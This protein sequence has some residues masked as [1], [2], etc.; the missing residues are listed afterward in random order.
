MNKQ[1]IEVPID[2]RYISEWVDFDTNLLRGHSIINK[3]ITGCGFT[4]YSLVNN[5]PTILCSPRK[6]LL[7]NKHQQH[8]DHTFLV[9]NS[10]EKILSVDSPSTNKTGSLLKTDFSEEMLTENL[11]VISNLKSSLITYLFNCKIAQITPKILVTYDS[12]KYVLEV[13][14]KELSNYSIIVDEFQNIFM[15]A[16]FKAETELNFIDVLQICPN[17]TYLSATPYIEEYLDELNEF[18]NLPYYELKWDQSHLRTIDIEFKKTSSISR[19]VDKIIQNYLSGN[20]PVKYD[21]KRNR[22]ESR[23]IVFYVNSVKM[24]KSI[25]SRNNLTQDQVNV[26][27]ANT[28]VNYDTLKK[29]KIS[30]GTAPLKGEPHKMFTF[31]TRTTYVGAD[32]YSTCASTVVVSDCKIDSLTSDIRMDFPQIMGRQ[33][34]KENVFRN[35]CTFIFNLSDNSITMEQFKEI[36]N[37]KLKESEQD[38]RNYQAVLTME[39]SEGVKKILTDFR[40]RITAHKYQNDYT[41]I[42]V[43]EGKPIINKL[44]LLAEKRA[45]ELRSNTYKTVFSV[46]DEF[47]DITEDISLNSSIEMHQ[48]IQKCM[49]DFNAQQIFE[50]KMKILC[51][52]F[53][54]DCVRGRLS[55]SD[56]P[57]IPKDYRNYL[58]YLG[59]E[60]I[61][62][63]GYREIVLKREIANIL[64][65]ESIK[66]ELVNLFEVGKRY[67]L[68]DI[69]ETLRGVYKTLGLTKTPKASDLEDYFEVKEVIF[70]NSETKKRDRGYEIIK[71]IE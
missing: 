19:E 71:L 51:K 42:S 39:G 31:C 41:G 38:L 67:L 53:L 59:P 32:F 54:D 14:D 70:Y 18:K 47:K 61:R 26:I 62:A 46:Y 23:E 21:E 50:N 16:S 8:Q 17:V 40:L 64:G 20:F 1:I 7:E 30:L 29:I 57:G 35:E 36:S 52:L 12:L 49:D 34:L 13:I 11:E 66:Q 43:K 5:I 55:V 28:K 58:N 37:A 69:K 2:I 56:V 9:V 3:T 45:F 27:C 44:V 60:R 10:G 24:I 6:F 4:H 65:N 48:F 63:I 15:D 33:R 22:F 25:I 68:R